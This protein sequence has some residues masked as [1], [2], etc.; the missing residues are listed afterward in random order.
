VGAID[1]ARGSGI[2]TNTLRVAR[3]GKDRGAGAP[4]GQTWHRWHKALRPRWW[5]LGDGRKPLGSW[6]CLEGPTLR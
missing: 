4:I 1:A 3:G 2:A 5:Q 6:Q